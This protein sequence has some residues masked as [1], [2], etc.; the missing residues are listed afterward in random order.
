MDNHIFLSHTVKPPSQ[1]KGELVVFFDI[2]EINSLT[3]R[4]NLCNW[5]VFI[6]PSVHGKFYILGFKGSF[7][8]GWLDSRH[9]LIHF[10]LEEDYMRLWLKGSW[11]LQ[12]Y[13]MR[14]FK[15]SGNFQLSI[16]PSV[17][18]AWIS[19]EA[20]KEH[21]QHDAPTFFRGDKRITWAPKDKDISASATVLP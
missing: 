8:I 7:T 21:K 13:P 11:S 4:F 10:D 20:G 16:E 14:V 12:E 5:E 1:F 9:V 15:W 17:I 2:E 18:L 6:R 19:P 3:T